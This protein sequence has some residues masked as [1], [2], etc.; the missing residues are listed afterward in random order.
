MRSTDN[1]KGEARRNGQW[2]TEVESCGPTWRC[3]I[4]LGPAVA[5]MERSSWM[6]REGASGE[7][8]AGSKSGAAML[9]NR[10]KPSWTSGQLQA[11]RVYKTSLAG[12][13]AV[14]AEDASLASATFRLAL[15]F[16]AAA[17]FVQLTNDR[18]PL[19]RSL[20]ISPRCRQLSST[21]NLSPTRPSSSSPPSSE[22]PEPQKQY[23]AAPTTT[24]HPR[25]APFIAEPPVRVL[26]PP[27]RPR[28]CRRIVSDDQHVSIQGSSRC[29]TGRT[30]RGQPASVD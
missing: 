16:L 19:L 30:S 28:S 29:W 1:G 6:L 20:E 25:A 14:Q 15:S 3:A 9:G 11:S 18:T 8:L 26:S 13:R 2:C 24:R 7:G 12:G 4:L 23:I 21:P 17:T 10:A 5:S 27:P 22:Q